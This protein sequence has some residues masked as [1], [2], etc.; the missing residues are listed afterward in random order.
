MNI[1]VD[2]GREWEATISD[3]TGIAA[4]LR[5]P[6]PLLRDLGVR[7]EKNIRTRVASRTGVDGRQ[8]KA[9][10]RAILESGQTLIDKGHM[11]GN[12]TAFGLTTVSIDV[13]FTSA[14]EGAKA[15]WHQ[16]GTRRG[17]PRRPFFGISR[18]DEIALTDT[19]DKWQRDMLAKRSL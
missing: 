14:R 16:E 19:A 3:L 9:S 2:A 8:Y 15:L 17:L 12:L 7:Q 6:R 13:G 10:K 5:D 4:D 1:T 11:I 18:S